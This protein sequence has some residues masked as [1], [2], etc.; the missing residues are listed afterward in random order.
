VNIFGP[1][2]ATAVL[3]LAL[4]CG[5]VAAA[6]KPQDADQEKLVALRDEKLAKPFLKKAT[7]L[8]D[9]DAALEAAKTSKKP[10]FAY[11]TRSYAK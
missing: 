9:Y 8:T 4:L 11:F 2:V 6:Q 1:K 10:I 5:G 3:G 7:W